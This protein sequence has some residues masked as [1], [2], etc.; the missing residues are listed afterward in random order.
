MR[1]GEIEFKVY[2]GRRNFFESVLMMA[3]TVKTRIRL[4]KP[5]LNHRA[6]DARNDWTVQPTKEVKVDGC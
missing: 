5:M 4:E 2:T 3:T 1:K 6:R